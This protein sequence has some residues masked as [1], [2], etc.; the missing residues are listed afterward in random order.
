MIKTALKSLAWIIG[1]IFSCSIHVVAMIGF[2]AVSGCFV[3]FWK[4]RG[5]RRLY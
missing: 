4:G 5:R 2:L 1:V 3:L